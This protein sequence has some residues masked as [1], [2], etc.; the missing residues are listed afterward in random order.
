MKKKITVLLSFIL[1][2]GMVLSACSSETENSNAA[3]NQ[4]EDGNTSKSEKQTVT[5]WAWNPD[6]NI[7]ALELAKEVYKS[8][9]GQA[10]IEIV[11]YASDD[12]VQKLN[13]GLNSGTS[14]GLP[15]IVLIEDYRA[16][17]FLNAYP[18]AFYDL[19]AYIHPEDFAEYKI[20]PT[21]VDGKQFGVPFDSG[22]AGVYVR[23]DY[24][25]EAGYSVEDL[26]DIDWNEF[27]E[28]GKAIK[29]KTGK[30]LLS[31]D[32]SD[33]STIRIMIQSAGSWYL[34]ESGEQP[35]LDGNPELKIALELY[36]Q[37][38]EEDLVNIHSDW[39][40]FVASANDGIVASVISGNWVTNAVKQAESQSGKWAIIPM[41]SLPGAENA[42]H[43]SNLGGSS[44]YVLN[45]PEA[46]AAADFLQKT[47]GSSAELY[48]QFLDEIDAIGTLK[49]VSD[50][51]VF[52]QEDEFFNGQ[53]IFKDFAEWTNEIPRVNYG[54]HT[55]ELED[56]LV[57]ELQNYLNGKDIDE[58]L[59]D[60]QL[61]AET[62]LK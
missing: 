15:S 10:E 31:I 9:G 41:P 45:G 20:G 7:K 56:I 14:S 13:T 36:K 53:K 62:Q 37:L 5:I 4:G 28:I 59:K 58:V 55:Y 38:I 57:V 16:Q 48:D 43:A 2:L 46:E 49:G 17:G 52:E 1:V 50:S 51:A 42:T 12:V 6:F 19:S 29:E 27:I 40:T 11:E 25:E 61:Q 35:Y 18:D 34:D 33:L 24:F 44:W 23:T 47:F 22:V 26:Q 32:S 39:N 3:G 21:S 54:M 8:Q 60:A 30:K